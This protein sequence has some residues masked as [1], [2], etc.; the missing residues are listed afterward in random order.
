MKIR[1]TKLEGAIIIEPAVFGDERG[2]FLETWNRDRYQEAGIGLPFVQDNISYS[3]KGVLRGLHF[4]YPHAQGKLV[5]VISGEV[6]DIAVDIRRGSPTFGESVGVMLTG[7]LKNQFYV[8]PGFAHGFCVVSD[9]AMFAYKCTDM[10]HPETEHS[11]AWDDPDLN[12]QWP[13]SQPRLSDKDRQAS[14]LK[15]LDEAVLPVYQAS[16]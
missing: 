6:F 11:L 15:D 4:Q 9:T 5:Q 14:R 10:Y 2:F 3:Q 12:I 16:Q 13:L 7:E 8:P 1:T